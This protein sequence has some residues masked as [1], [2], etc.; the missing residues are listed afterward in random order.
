MKPLFLSSRSVSRH[1][2]WREGDFNS[3]LVGAALADLPSGRSMSA[4]PHVPVML[5]AA[6]EIVFLAS[7]VSPE[8]MNGHRKILLLLIPIIEISPPSE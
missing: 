7:F 3:N 8:T 1:P 5:G 4:E 6:F 2:S